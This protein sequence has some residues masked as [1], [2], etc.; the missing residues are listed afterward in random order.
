MLALTTMLHSILQ[1]NQ[2]NL[3]EKEKM[4]EKNSTVTLTSDYQIAEEEPWCY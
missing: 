1:Q 2:H 4:L 3:S